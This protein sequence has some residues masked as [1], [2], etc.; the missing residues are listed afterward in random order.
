MSERW[1][2]NASPLIV[3]ARAGLEDLLLKLP[4]Q[5]V[6]PR[7]VEIEIQAG[8]ASDPA[9]QILTAGKFSIVETD[10][11]EEILTWDLGWGETAV[12]SYVLTN[13]GWTAIL[14]DR[15][16][17]ACARSYSIPFKGTLAVVILA[18][19]VGEID[20]AA[21]AMRLLQAAGL[22]LDE[23]VIREALKLTVGEDW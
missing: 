22:R 4:E 21:G 19:Q 10:S 20:S 9:R 1:V 2:L 17:R 3:M 5:V 11:R 7:L 13:P 12:L 14:D 15:A 6:V 8:P 16:A 23:A 18:K